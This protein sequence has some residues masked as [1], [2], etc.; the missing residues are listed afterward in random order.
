MSKFFHQTWVLSWSWSYGSWIYNDL[1][2]QCLSPLTLQVRIPFRP[3]VLDTTLCDKV[4]QWFSPGTPVSST[5]KTDHRNITEILLKV[6]FNTITLTLTLQIL[7]KLYLCTCFKHKF[8]SL[9]PLLNLF[10]DSI[11]YWKMFR[12]SICVWRRCT[13]KVYAKIVN[14]PFY[15]NVSG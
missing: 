2:N 3:D 1:C 6:A 5:N 10:D 14:T 8:D 7:F 9:S 4:C 15:V 12:M 11:K 13:G